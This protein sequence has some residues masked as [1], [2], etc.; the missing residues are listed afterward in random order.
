MT[1]NAEN[2]THVNERSP[3]RREINTAWKLVAASTVAR[4]QQVQA[5]TVE[6]VQSK[7]MASNHG[8]GSMEIIA[9]ADAFFPGGFK[10]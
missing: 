9:G 1:E 6:K 7:A 10:P 3:Q 8:N 4:N 5:R 2:S